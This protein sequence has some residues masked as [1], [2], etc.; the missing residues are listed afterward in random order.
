MLQELAEKGIKLNGE[1]VRVAFVPGHPFNLDPTKLRNYLRLNFS[2][3]A[4]EV[5]EKGIVALAE[6]IKEK[7]R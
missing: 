4:P 5:I 7:L 3:N 1:T 6:A 2:M